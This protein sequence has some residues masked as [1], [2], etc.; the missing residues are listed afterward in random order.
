MKKKLISVIL[1]AA[2]AMTMF[3]GCGAGETADTNT[4]AEV[5]DDASAEETAEDAAAED[6]AEETPEAAT[7][8]ATTYGTNTE[9]KFIVGFDQEFPPMGFVDENGEYTGFDLALA[10][11]V[12]TRLDLEFVA[13]PISWDAK[14][15]ELSSGTI[16][17]IWNG[18][19]IN[20]RE[21][22]YTFSQP[23][24]NNRQVF[25]V[26][27]DSDIKSQ[28]DLA[29]KIVEVQADSSAEAALNDNTE[30]TGTFGNMQTVPDYNTAMMDLEQG[31]VDAIAMD[32]IVAAY[33]I[34]SKESQFTI[35]DE[36]ISHEEYGIGF[37][38]GNEKLKESVETILTEMR[39]DGTLEKIST[40]W[41]GSDITTFGK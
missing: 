32:E 12:A 20:G 8:T 21:D 1:T 17:C 38:K 39:E 2:M 5:S 22:D 18:F 33:Q 11:E 3:A 23:Y 25:V 29:G 37:L 19:T 7:D 27:S 41:F 34:Q 31:A 26:S 13:Q 35:L 15:M 24:L 36:E 6:A 4:E 30:L 9:G 16:D 14:D 10:E 28:A 40:E